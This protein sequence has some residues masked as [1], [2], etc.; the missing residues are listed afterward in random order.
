MSIIITH[1]HTR[2]MGAPAGC[3][4][5]MNIINMV[6]HRTHT[7]THTH[8]TAALAAWVGLGWVGEGEEGEGHPRVMWVGVVGGGGDCLKVALLGA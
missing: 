5:N 2:Y 4:R 3:P 6:V 8:T 7:H 1:T